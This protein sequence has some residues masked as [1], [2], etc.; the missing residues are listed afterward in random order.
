MSSRHSRVSMW[1]TRSPRRRRRSSAPLAQARQDLSDVYR[2]VLDLHLEHGLSAAE[3]GSALGRPAGTVRTQFVRGLEL[4]RRRLPQGFV[5]G[6][7]F[8]TFDTAALRAMRAV[9][10]RHA[11]EVVPVGGS[12]A[13]G[14]G[15]SLAVI[16]AGAMQKKLVVVGAIAVLIALGCWVAA[17]L[18]RSGDEG[19]AA[20]HERA[21]VAVAPV[22][23]QHGAG[24]APSPAS[25]PRAEAA[26]RDPVPSVAAATGSLE[27]LAR[28]RSDDAP[29]HA[30]AITVINTDAL[31]E[32]GGCSIVTDAGGRAVFA[33]LPPGA[34][35]VQA[36]TG[37]HREAVVVAGEETTVTLALDGVAV[38]GQVVD[39]RGEPVAGA[40]VWVSS[41]VV[42]TRAR[43]PDRPF[44]GQYGQHTLRTDAQGRFATRMA[45]R[46]CVAAFKPGHGPS[47]TQYPLVGKG[48]AQRGPI[49]IVLP[50]LPAGGT[51]A[52]VVRGRDAAPLAGALVLAG[53]EVPHLTDLE[54]HRATTP[55]QRAS[56]DAIGV[57]TL[58]PLPTG[59]IPVQVRAAGHGPWQ[60]EVDV[61]A[62]VTT[63]LDVALV[64]GGIV[65]GVV[66]DGTGKPL[67]DALV[68]H[69]KASA[70]RSSL[71]MT[72]ANGAYQ[73]GHLPAGEL[74]L[75]AFH[76][77][78]GT[79]TETLAVTAGAAVRWD[80]RL[81]PRAAITG[82][83]LDA[84]GL[85]VPGCYVVAFAERGRSATTFADAGG[86]FTLSPLDA[87]QQYSVTAEVHSPSGGVARPRRESVPAGTDVELRVSAAQVPTARLR[88]RVL[89]PDG[90]P[91]VGCEVE[92]STVGETIGSRHPIAED[93]TFELGPFHA[94]RVTDVSGRTVMMMWTM[95]EPD[96]SATRVVLPDSAAT[97][98][99]LC[100]DGRRGSV[101]TAAAPGEPLVIPLERR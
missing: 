63:L 29:A 64:D 22:D 52:V 98:S 4:L 71:A 89:Q 45:G 67:A 41:E 42:Y 84:D 68:H 47:L 24:A 91:A 59:R 58:T 81:P 56:T 44:H 75:A 28:W 12:V 100:D 37:A 33:A 99:A 25:S 72:D 51:L 31:G 82:R 83:V 17:A 40:D 11:A 49:E 39:H 9:V 13:A 79:G 61:V 19:L 26:L 10:V 69:G 57:A 80:A 5:A 93:G 15:L 86:R 20:V 76:E 8:A 73:L 94:R 2:P 14:A 18:P 87:G 90:R 7:A 97:L 6:L 60:G 95:Q 1:R 96:G 77:D 3:I 62:G 92:S 34:V 30:L 54:H 23:D 74:T 66:L 70:L 85:P 16:G 38:N 36:S 101:P 21:E 43:M 50:L 46:Q 48:R 65:T 32:F 35:L 88:G 55:A 27:V 78:W 53:H